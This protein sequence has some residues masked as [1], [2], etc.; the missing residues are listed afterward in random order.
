MVMIYT[1][2]LILNKVALLQVMI[3][4]P[5]FIL[6]KS[7]LLYIN[8]FHSEV[9]YARWYNYDKRQY[10]TYASYYINDLHPEVAYASWYNYDKH[11]YVTYA[12][13]YTNALHPEVAYAS[14]YNYDKHQCLTYGLV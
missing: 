13:Y 9:A 12:S 7:I 8:N 11:Q 10:L 1:C 4:I 3:H 5:K 6:R 2:Q 14:W